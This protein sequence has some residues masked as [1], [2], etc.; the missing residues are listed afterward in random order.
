MANNPFLMNEADRAAWIAEQKA[1]A[2]HLSPAESRAI[3]ELQERIVGSRPG[4]LVRR[5]P[6]PPSEQPDSD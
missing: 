1:S 2:R 6:V 3:C 5:R 4:K